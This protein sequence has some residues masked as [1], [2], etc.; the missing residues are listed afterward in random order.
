MQLSAGDMSS[1]VKVQIFGYA[2]YF[3][4]DPADVQS[5]H[6]PKHLKLRL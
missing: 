2:H 3:R 6:V 1:T 5:K 4:Q